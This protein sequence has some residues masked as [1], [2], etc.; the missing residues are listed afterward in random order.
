[1]TII[2][3]TKTESY[4][5]QKA[6]LVVYTILQSFTDK[7]D[8]NCHRD[9]ASLIPQ[10]SWFYC[11][12]GSILDSYRENLVALGGESCSSCWETGSD[13]CVPVYQ[14]TH[15]S[16]QLH[17]IDVL[18]LYRFGNKSIVSPVRHV[19]NKSTGLNNFQ[20]MSFRHTRKPSFLKS[21][22][23]LNQKLPVLIRSN[24]RRVYKLVC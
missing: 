13:S 11:F 20:F 1:M 8:R 2:L 23:L 17:L 14:W 7:P 9:S 19:V 5:E 16:I 18:R 3:E 6:G 24:Y 10:V 15:S 12:C 4:R 22:P 21:H